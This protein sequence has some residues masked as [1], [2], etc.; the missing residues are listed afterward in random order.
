MFGHRQ[1]LYEGHRQR[2]YVDGTEKEVWRR[3]DDRYLNTHHLL[4]QF[5]SSDGMCWTWGDAGEFLFWIIDDD[6]RE[7]R[8]DRVHATIEGH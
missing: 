1:H 3:S 7:R 4:M 2:L 8:F 6:L 5:S